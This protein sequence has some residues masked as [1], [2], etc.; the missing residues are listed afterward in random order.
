MPL[1][2]LFK[3]YLKPGGE[4]ILASEMRKT[5]KDFYNYLKTDFDI[6]VE[7]KSLRSD[8]G[9]TRIMLFKMRFYK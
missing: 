6:R 2:Q 3:S 1:I 4:I 9:A 7:K 5:G 8:N